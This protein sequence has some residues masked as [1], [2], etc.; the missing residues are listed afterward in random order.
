MYICVERRRAYVCAY[1]Y[2]TNNDENYNVKTNPE[3]HPPLC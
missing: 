1:V 2:V 3:R